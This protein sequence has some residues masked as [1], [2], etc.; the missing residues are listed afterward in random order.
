MA[1]TP[2][3][4]ST[5][6]SLQGPPSMVVLDEAVSLLRRTPVAT[7]SIYYLGALPFCLG[8]V[9]F[10][11]DMTQG[12]DAEVHM[13]GEALL[14]TALY[15]WMRTCQAVF[16]RKLVAQLEGED[17]EPWNARRLA[18]TALLQIIFSGALVIVYPIAVIITLPFA[19]VHAFFHNISI[20]ATGSKS[21]VRGSLAE[22]VDA[23]RP[24]PKQNHLILG[25]QFC[26]WVFL[27]LNVAV[28]CSALPML[29]NMFFGI[30]TIFDESESAW[31]NSSFYLDVFVL[32]YLIINPVS[33]AIYALRYFYGR[34]RL[35]GADLKAEL[36]R[37]DK[38]RQEQAP[39]RVL[40]ALLV[41][42]AAFLATPLR[43][44][45]SLSPAPVVASP[46]AAPA[47][48]TGDLDNAIQKTLKKDE[49]AWRLPRPEVKDAQEEGWL[50]RTLHGF[51]HAL[52][53]WLE[54][55]MKPI[56]EFLRWLFD[57]QGAHDSST[58]G[59]AALADMPWTTL[60]LVVL[61]LVVVCLIFILVRYYR[62]GAA[63]PAA[64][65][66]SVPTKT[67]VDLESENVRA[68]ELPEDSWLALARELMDKGELRLALRALY[69][70][71]LSL[72]AH[73]QLVRLAAAKSN[74]DYLQELTRRLRGNTEAVQ[75]FREN[76]RLFEASWYGTHA[77]DNAIIEA[78]L[79]NHQQV[80]GHAAA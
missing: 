69:L 38:L 17:A 28:F 1:A 39:G 57:K 68:D 22:A 66:V 50:M 73:H 2:S 58:S 15:C 8:L 53:H 75:F 55:A 71:T 37:Q 16:A 14:L 12:A 41:L 60:F 6:T 48:A 59:W 21:T 64:V 3:R 25:I 47:P 20:V 61:A 76:I 9:Y 78:M 29:L 33:K 67:V 19:W 23:S 24:W 51:L 42:L 74:R 56:V 46:A 36:R 35:T 63:G 5:Q 13:A 70:A 18:N 49:F 31:Q 27:F 54:S 40:V 77:V 30:L 7:F 65:V 80:R 72:L 11:F 44:Q 45:T 62:R 34:A 43:A 10:F 79:A 26:G 52:K 32:C 4:F